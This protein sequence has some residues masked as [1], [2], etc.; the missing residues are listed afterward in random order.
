[1]AMTEEV[2]DP[3]DDSYYHCGHCTEEP[4]L[5][6]VCPIC[7]LGKPTSYEALENLI[8]HIVEIR[9]HRQEL[10]NVMREKYDWGYIDACE[11]ILSKIRLL[12]KELTDGRDGTGGD[13][14]I[15]G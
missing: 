7:G 5:Q 3:G 12:L 13:K 2:I 8:P 6:I 9:S 11:A 10:F 1:M 14:E 15:L 4:C